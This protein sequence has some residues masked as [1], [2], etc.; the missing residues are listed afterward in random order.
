M[1]ESAGKSL[2]FTAA[3]VPD[4]YQRYGELALET[5]SNLARGAKP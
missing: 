1:T 4:R 5:C 2:A 3:S